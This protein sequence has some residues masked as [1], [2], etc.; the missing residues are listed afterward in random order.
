[1]PSFFIIAFIW[2]GL[3]FPGSILTTPLPYSYRYSVIKCKH[4]RAG[5]DGCAT[6]KQAIAAGNNEHL[7]PRAD[8]RISGC[9]MLCKSI[10]PLPDE[11]CNIIS[12]DNPVRGGRKGCLQPFCPLNP[13][14]QPAV[15][16]PDGCQPCPPG[17][18]LTDPARG[19]E[20]EPAAFREE[21]GSGTPSE[22]EVSNDLHAPKRTVLRVSC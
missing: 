12:D 3:T 13:E 2:R 15:G 20:D 11:L 17:Q 18:Y 6:G 10:L 22:L 5:N 19:R 8:L 21:C 14:R 7:V 9:D 16:S 4:F 1:M